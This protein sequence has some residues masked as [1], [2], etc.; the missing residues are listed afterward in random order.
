[1][2]AATNQSQARAASSRSR[3]ES[4]RTLRVIRKSDRNQASGFEL[5]D[6]LIQSGQPVVHAVAE[7]KNHDLVAEPGGQLVGAHDRDGIGRKR[8]GHSRSVS[9]GAT[10][11]PGA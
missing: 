2:R 10:G 7:A 5:L 6:Q 9:H 11:P 4:R 3:R 8:L 1:M